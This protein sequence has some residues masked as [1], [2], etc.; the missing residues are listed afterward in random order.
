MCGWWRVCV[1]GV[2][3]SP[4]IVIN[5]VL[6]TL[7]SLFASIRV[8]LQESWMPHT[9]PSIGCA[10]ARILTRLAIQMRSG[11]LWARV[12]SSIHICVCYCAKVQTRTEK[13]YWEVIWLQLWR[14]RKM[15]PYR[16]Y[17]RFYMYDRRLECVAPLLHSR[18]FCVRW[19]AYVLLLRHLHGMFMW[20]ITLHFLTTVFF[21][22]IWR[23]WAR[24]SCNT[25][26]S[27]VFS[28]CLLFDV[29]YIGI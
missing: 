6:R 25:Q 2:V 28:V 17:P 3:N 15:K 1:L 4:G 9:I 19:T 13:I 21:Q 16:N 8:V 24:I 11:M 10:Y 26:S 29:P 12:R 7:K 22:P 27:R 5:G 14:T 20:K 23:R 18:I